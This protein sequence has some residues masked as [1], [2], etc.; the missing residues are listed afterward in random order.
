MV[1]FRS[2]FVG[3]TT[4]EYSQE[5]FDE[6]TIGKCVFGKNLIGLESLKVLINPNCNLLII[7]DLHHVGMKRKNTINVNEFQKGNV[8]AEDDVNF[9]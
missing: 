8:N 2:A 7:T 5:A 4:P 6:L 3:Q 9:E 1:H